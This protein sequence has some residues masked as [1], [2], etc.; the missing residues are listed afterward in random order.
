MV[1]FVMD[2]AGTT[3]LLGANPG[4]TVSSYTLSTEQGLGLEYITVDG[5]KPY[6]ME[7]S[8]TNQYNLYPVTGLSTSSAT[9][10]THG[11]STPTNQIL[12]A[13]S[14]G[15]TLTASVGSGTL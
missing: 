3:A 2:S 1:S 13:S 14:Y 9:G 15:D 11:Q 8:G 7:G 5:A 10:G 6:M 4:G 12:S